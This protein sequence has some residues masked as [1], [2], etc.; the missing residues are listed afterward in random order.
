MDGNTA[1]HVASLLDDT[2]YILL[3]LF[4]LMSLSK[5]NLKPL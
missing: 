1:L 2:E 4:F 3:T 5:K